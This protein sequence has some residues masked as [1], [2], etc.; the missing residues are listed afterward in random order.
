MIISHKHKFIFIKCPK[1]AGTSIQVAL[2]PFCG[3]DDIVT[4]MRP[5]EPPM[6]R[7]V[8]RNGEDWHSHSSSIEI[9][10]RLPNNVWNR[11][12]KFAFERNPWD[13]TISNY[14]FRRWG[15]GPKAKKM[16]KKMRDDPV[17]IFPEWLERAKLASNYQMY[18]GSD[19][20]AIMANFIG[21]YENLNDDFAFICDRIGLVGAGELPLMKA[22]YREDRRHY[23]E[24]FQG[25]QKLIDIV[26]KAYAREIKMFGFEFEEK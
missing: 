12:Y 23:S 10:S 16:L 4:S 22:G 21:L 26:A 14:W 7:Y 1:T 15:R 19:G 6:S 2:E 9:R 13:R 3:D 8:P 20:T 18:T 5:Y 25:D 17:A 11:Y 24:Y